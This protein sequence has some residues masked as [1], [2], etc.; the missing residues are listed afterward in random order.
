MLFTADDRARL[1]RIETTLARIESALASLPAQMPTPTLP[2]DAIE[3]EPPPRVDEAD[4][5]WAK[6]ASA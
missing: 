6:K 1:E 3:Y 5:A 4:E 2:P